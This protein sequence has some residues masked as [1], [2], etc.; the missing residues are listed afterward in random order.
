MLGKES[1]WQASLATP[2]QTR[3]TSNSTPKT[4]E[5]HY[6]TQEHML[7]VNND[8]DIA[9][10]DHQN[11]PDQRVI[12]CHKNEF[13]NSESSKQKNKSSR[14]F[15]KVCKTKKSSAVLNWY[16]NDHEIKLLKSHNIESFY[17]DISWMV[18]RQKFQTS[19]DK[20]LENARDEENDIQLERTLVIPNHS[21]Q[22]L[23]YL[24]INDIELCKVD[25][26]CLFLNKSYKLNTKLVI[27]GRNFVYA[28]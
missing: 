6:H 18:Y 27:W 16:K 17:G 28:I 3:R 14:H 22:Q 26:M 20:I 11:S 10:T 4:L 12:Y 2:E 8:T 24:S 15:I 13:F 9:I 21:R 1:A 7:Y 19:I 5:N 23:T 25:N